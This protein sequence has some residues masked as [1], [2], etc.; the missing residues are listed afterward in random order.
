MNARMQERR[1]LEHDLREAIAR[2]E[3]ELHYQPLVSSA[4]NQV[5]GVE[6]LVRWNHPGRGRVPPG[7]FIP[8]AEESGLIVPLGEWVLRRACADA[9][10]WPPH[11]KVAVNLSPLQFKS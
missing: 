5:V 10:A 8:L 2:G 9:A 1:Q 3:L 11:I 6:A 4:T 7:D